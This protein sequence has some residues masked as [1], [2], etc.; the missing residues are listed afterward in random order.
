MARKILTIG[1]ELASDKTTHEEFTS[2]TSLLD[3]DIILFKP[4]ID[5]FITYD[6]QY[7]GRPSLSDRRSFQLKEACEHW[8]REIK[9]AV[10]SGKTVIIFL[11]EIQE[12][13]IDTGDRQYSGTGRNRATTRIVS[14]Y[15]NY[16]SIPF[17]LAPTNTS[18]TAVRL[19]PKGAEVLAPYWSEF[20][21]VSEYN[22]LLTN[23]NLSPCLLTKNGEKTVGVLIRS[24]TSSGTL[25]CLP[26]VEFY[27]DEFI[28]DEDN[29]W[30]DEAVQFSA[31][32]ISAI[33][34]LDAALHSAG[35]IT[36][37]PEWASDQKYALAAERSLRVDLLDV[38]SQLEAAQRNKESIIEKLQSV[39][40]LRGLL[41]EKG[42]PLENAIIDGLRLLGFNANQY[43]EGSSEFDVVFESAEGRLI[44][45]AEGKDSKAINVDKLRQ[46]AMN[47]HEDL[48]RDEV[49]APAKGVLFGNGYRLTPP[50]ERD[51][52]FTEKCITAAQSSSTALVATQDLF[53]AARYL[54]DQ[55]D[56]SYAAE[57]RKAILNSSGPVSFPEAPFAGSESVSE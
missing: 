53:R 14:P 43:K 19:A 11:P 25:A 45:E 35:E 48:A 18:G 38:E 40:L 27:R 36:P 28:N 51:I 1:L 54:A 12:V 41:Y 50:A 2:R 24:K 32:F 44:G 3:W 52:A 5:E 16:Y 26:N 55:E 9:Q 49:I 17:D 23:T 31:R 33:V 46:L 4:L 22:V 7:K 15:N 8:R 34:S 20:A 30:T 39:G 56:A 42:K 29:T 6:D 10:E 47:I 57:C 13:Y 37:E 21:S